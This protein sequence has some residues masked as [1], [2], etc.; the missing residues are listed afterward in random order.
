[1]LLAAAEDQPV[2]VARDDEPISSSMKY[3]PGSW[4]IAAPRLETR[5]PR[6]DILKD[7]VGPVG[8]LDYSQET[9]RGFV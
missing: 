6:P 3:L 2:D 9:V 7:W 8:K 4:Q 5:E 1:M